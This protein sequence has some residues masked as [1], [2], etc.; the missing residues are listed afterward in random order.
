LV[1]A[2]GLAPAAFAGSSSS[3]LDISADGKLLLVANSDNGSV[4]V[5]DTTARQALREIKV[6][7]KPE[8]V[9]W[10]GN[11]P[12]AAVTVYK[13]DTVVF[14]DALTGQIVQKLAVPD[15]PYG[16]VASKDGSRAWITNDYPGLVTEIS[17]G[18][19][20]R[21]D[22]KIVAPPQIKIVARHQVGSFLRGICLSPD[23][24]RLYVTEFYTGVLLAVDPKTGQVADKWVGH[25]TDNLA[26]HVV[27][28]PT[29]PKAYVSHVRSKITVI[30]GSGSIFPQLSI[31]D[32][33]PAK[34]DT[35]RRKSIG[36]DSYNGTSTVTNAYEAALSPDGKTIYTIY[37]AT[38]DMNISRVIDDDYREMSP[39]GGPIRVGQNPRAVRVSPDGKT[40]YISNTLDFEVGIHN[41]A[42]MQK[43]GSVKVCEPAKT[44]EWVRG[45]AL[46]NMALLPMTGPRWVACVSCH[47]DGHTDGRTWQNPEGLR[48]TPH[49]FGLAHTHPLH[50]SADRDEV[51]DFEYTIR[52]RLMRGTGL[53]SPAPKP[54]QGFK[55][56]ELEETLGGRSK[57][58]DALAIYT[59]SFEA[60]TL[61][62][63]NPA[64]GKLS[65]AAER[66]KKVFFSKETACGTCHSGPYY[67]D[68]RLEKPFKL[69]DVGTG[70]DD[71]SEKMGPRYDT[72][73]LLYVY[74]TAPYLHHGKAATL[75]DV[76]TTH[77]KG[78]K[79]GKTSHL[80]KDELDDLVE[81]M[82]ALP[83]EKPPL[84]T[85]N[86]VKFRVPPKQ[87]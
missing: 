61:S 58:L 43:L 45:K 81:F 64:P 38:N 65:E 50:W 73:T 87:E 86:T 49:F 28:H 32:L 15:E 5:V 63:H 26:R 18:R 44:P 31:C 72:P 10:I 66:G 47:P 40:V 84:E 41:A 33:V 79:H 36:M 14:F 29:R 42:N 8:G 20:D 54:K 48:K 69:H 60:T 57:D 19:R 25:T 53:V 22:V 52:S 59:N 27:L 16:I 51:Q 23:E 6:G 85:P 21:Q 11:G 71:P 7:E 82:K 56:I 67:S 35:S 24:S 68:S 80:K 62:P 4:T 76:L 55:P 3:L 2:G 17:V 75:L 12:L 74:R 70:S 9:A 83:Y 34:P 30:D 39:I 46:F 13:E 1:L 77:N 78:D 37:A